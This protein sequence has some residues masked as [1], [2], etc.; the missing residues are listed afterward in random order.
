MCG[1]SDPKEV[2]PWMM[3]QMG[4]SPPGAAV[5]EG[6]APQAA[7]GAATAKNRAPSLASG[8]AGTAVSSG[9]DLL[10][11]AFMPGSSGFKTLT[12]M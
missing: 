12:G 2:Q 10:T 4:M 8:G 1:V 11:P 7:S 5:P 3:R 9:V 6:A